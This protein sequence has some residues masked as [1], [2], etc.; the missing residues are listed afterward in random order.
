MPLRDRIAGALL[1]LIVLAAQTHWM[2]PAIIFLSGG[3]VVSYGVW[4]KPAGRTMP[5][6]FYPSIC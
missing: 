5:L 4:I 6:R 1:V 3:L 2:G